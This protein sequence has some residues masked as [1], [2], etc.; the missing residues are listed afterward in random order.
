MLDMM[1]SGHTSGFRKT[2][3]EKALHKYELELIK[4]INGEKN[5]YRS[6]EERET[7]KKDTNHL[8]MA[9]N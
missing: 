5:M 6:K 4:H 8:S 7:E 9:A 1:E 2:V 3:V